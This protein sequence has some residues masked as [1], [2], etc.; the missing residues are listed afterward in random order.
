MATVGRPRKHDER[1]GETLLDV[2][3]ALLAE[4]GPDSVSVRAVADATG[5]TTRA[6]YSV[7]GSKDGLIYGLCRR[8]Y[9][10]L[11][12]RVEALP[13]TADPLADLV[14]VGTDAFRSFA[15]DHPQLFRMTFERVTHTVAAEPSVGEALAGS[16]RALEAR[17][18]R[19][20]AAGLL[21]TAPVA[22]LVFQFHAVAQGLAST[23]LQRLP[24]PL[25]AAWWS[26]VDPSIDGRSVWRET[27]LAFVVGLGSLSTAESGRVDAGRRDVPLQRSRRRGR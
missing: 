1:T 9:T 8:A 21:G 25:G 26:D 16:Y 23:E 19:A 17:I 12:E 7:F 4:G 22:Q 6:V 24:P 2:A 18:E 5:T 20:A 14:A 11:A 13:V 10:L 3:E 15:L 27:L